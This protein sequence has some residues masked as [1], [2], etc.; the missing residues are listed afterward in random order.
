MPV[1]RTTLL[2]GPAAATFNGHTFFARD[3]ILVTPALEV[4]AVDSEAQGV[5]DATVSSAPVTIQ[6][7]PSAPFSDLIALYPY[8]LGTPGMSFFGSADTPLVLVA[9]N[10][11]RLTFSAVAITQMP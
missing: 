1:T 6:F 2:S 11:V 8:M 9:A 10:G 4:D 7:T 5:L 3:G